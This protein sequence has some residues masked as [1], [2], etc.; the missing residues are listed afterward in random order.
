MNHKILIITI[1]AFTF[2][3]LLQAQKII[4]EKAPEWVKS[5]DIPEKSAIS[6][7]EIQTGS[8]SKLVDYQVNLEENAFYIHEVT[9][10]VSYSGITDASQISVNYDTS[11]Q[12][13]KVHHLYIWRKGEKIDRTASLS[14]EILNNE[15]DLNQGIYSGTINAYDILNDIRKDDLIDF[16]YTMIGDNP[17]FDNEKYLILPLETTNPVD[18]YSVRVL[19]PSNKDYSYECED[20]DS[21]MVSTE[22]NGYR[23]IEIQRENVKAI[24]FEEN[25]PAWVI[26]YKYFILSSFKSWI[27]VNT[28]AQNVFALTKEPELEDVFDEIFTGNETTE[29]KI[30]KIINYVQDDIRY[31]GIETGIGSIKPFP[32]EQVVKQR[33]GDCKDKSLLLVSLLK[34]IGIEKAYPVLANVNLQNEIDSHFPSNHIF[35]HCIVTFCYDG[36]SYW[37]DPTMTS[38]GGDFK[39]LNNVGFGKVL[40]IGQP[41]DTL[42]TM[43]PVNVE[44][45]LDIVD[46]YTINSFT[47]PAELKMTSIRHG[48]ESDVRRAI[49]EYLTLDY[50]TDMLEKDL[51]LQFPVVNEMSEPEIADDIDKNIFSVTY[52]YQVDGFW[53]DGDKAPNDATNGLWIFRFEPV[54]LYQ[55]L[56]LSNCEERKYDYQLMY[57]LNMDYRVIFHFPKD[58]LVD[59]DYDIFDN[60]AFTYEERIEQLSSNSV[61]INYKLKTKSNFIK[62]CDYKEMC[63][64][65][66]SIIKGFPVVF[67]FYK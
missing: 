51:K 57:P 22:V 63:E 20:C 40:V 35:N 38:Q 26:P 36:N 11:Y 24:K 31:M 28:W 32:P 29:D 17:I 49:F 3:Q 43:P 4:F 50:I 8:Y 33:F 14:F 25:L 44:S 21:L 55:D 19:Y 1:I 7:Y 53:Q 60:Q 65:K 18:F 6:K 62:A 10:I 13:L 30:N 64:Q 46:E 56:N 59:D 48:L 2:S 54:M 37:V 5:M 67:Y 47:G 27:D 52:N 12:Q 58:I 34:Q 39:H 66:N 42:Q 15:H 45:S 16:A 61:Q 23:V 41:A 9:N